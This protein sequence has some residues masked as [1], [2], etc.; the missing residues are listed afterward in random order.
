MHLNQKYRLYS[1]L[2]IAPSVLA[3]LVFVY[4]FI[5]FTGVASFI[6][7]T[8]MKIDFT[9]VGFN[10]YIRLFQTE[11]FL[12]DL[13]NTLTFTVLFLLITIVIG[14]LLAILVD[15]NIKGESLFRNI[16][17][18]PMAFSFIVTGVV[19]RWLL[20]PGN[21]ITG[22]LGVNLIFEKIGLGFLANGWY[23]DP[24]IGIRAVVIAA[25]W[26]YA[27]YIMAL[28][29]AGIRG[30]PVEIVEA[31]R[32][33]GASEINVYRHIILP[34]VRPITLSAVIILGHISLKIFDLVVSMTGPG[35]GF[36]TDVP[37]FFMY[38]TTFR[39]NRFAE[40]SAI[41]IILLLLVAILVVPYLINSSKVEV[42]R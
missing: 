32:V 29:L 10:N 13:R 25:V 14:L 19:W 11:R 27:G 3:I 4:G 39:G 15:Q 1:I 40:G 16:F 8:K 20:A 37:A 21:E 38:D 24:R 31:A 35:T 2:L 33:D 6:N 12:I 26:Q 42:E 9:F 41:A 17:L 18:F 5:A 36:S 7:W 23:T 22:A 30:I 34:L 28:Y